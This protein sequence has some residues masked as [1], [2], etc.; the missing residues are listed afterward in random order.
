MGSKA[1][2]EKYVAFLR[3]INVGGNKKVEMARL[4]KVFTSMGFSGVSTY[5]NSGN[6]IFRAGKKDFS[7]IEAALEKAFGFKIDVIIRDEENIR[8][9]C[10]KIPAGFQN[11]TIQKTD[12]LFLKSEFDKKG[13]IDLL[14]TNPEVDTLL[15]AP[16]AIVWSVKRS[17]YA[18]SGMKNFIGS[19][20]YKNMTAR[21]VNTVRKISDLLLEGE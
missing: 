12:V 16:G 19:V 7:R 17:S 3:G 11:D 1:V 6:V 4:R 13:T 14:R 9:L 21:N 8:K 20:V 2:T 18:K 15:Y 10:G 5:I